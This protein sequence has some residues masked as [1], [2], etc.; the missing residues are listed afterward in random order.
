[1]HVTS[2]QNDLSPT[3]AVLRQPKFVQLDSKTVAFMGWLRRNKKIAIRFN[4]QRVA[5]VPEKINAGSDSARLWAQQV[6]ANSTWRHGR[7]VLRFSLKY[8]VP[9]KLT[10]MLAVPSEEMKLFREKERHWQQKSADQRE[11]E[12][13]KAR[14]KRNW[15]SNRN[16]NWN[17][18]SGGD[19]EIRITMPGAKSVQALLPDGRVLDLTRN[20][21]V[22]GGNFEIPATEP[23]GT[24]PVQIVARMPDGSIVTCSWTYQVDRTPPKGT[25]KFYLENGR[26]MLEVRSEKDLAEVAAYAEDG[27]KWV[28]KQVEPGV[29]RVELRGNLSLRLTVVMKDRASNKGEITCFWQR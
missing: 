23:E 19:P 10:A 24:Y 18:G 21:S 25:A 6:L 22:W 9:S 4:G 17:S 20:G 8:G 13:D 3:F 14:E 28:L 29:Y 16:Q 11:D 7:D 2:G 1:M 26:L 5:V 12:L 27:T 15:D